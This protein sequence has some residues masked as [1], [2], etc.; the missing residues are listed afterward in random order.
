MDS[1]SKPVEE[2]PLDPYYGTP[3]GVEA[4]WCPN[5]TPLPLAEPAC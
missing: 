5:G 4:A 3:L 1:T 2:N